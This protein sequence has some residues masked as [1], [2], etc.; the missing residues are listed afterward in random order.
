MTISIKVHSVTT[1][2][3]VTE[4]AEKAQA[5]PL[6]SCHRRLIEELIVG[7]ALECATKGTPETLTFL[8]GKVVAYQELLVLL[9]GHPQE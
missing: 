9:S 4:V 6:A 8:Q 5:V 1:L 7:S 2:D 3:V